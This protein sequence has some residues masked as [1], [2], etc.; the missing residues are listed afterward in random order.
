MVFL[1]AYKNKLK[2]IDL[3]SFAVNNQKKKLISTGL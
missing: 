3:Q 2:L 1:I